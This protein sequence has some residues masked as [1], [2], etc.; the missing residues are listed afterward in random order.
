MKERETLFGGSRGLQHEDDR[1]CFRDS[2]DASVEYYGSITIRLRPSNP[3]AY[4]NASSSHISPPERSRT[5]RSHLNIL[6]SAH[7]YSPSG[8]S[9]HLKHTPRVLSSFFTSLELPERSTRCPH[10]IISQPS[11]HSSSTARSNSLPTALTAIKP[12]FKAT[13]P[14]TA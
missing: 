4:E 10:G 12:A 2:V 7:L 1:E 14:Q 9:N 8:K 3:K 13:A 6:L 11:T 5:A